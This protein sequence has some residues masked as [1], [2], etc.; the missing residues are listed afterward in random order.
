MK[1]FVKSF[2]GFQARGKNSLYLT[3]DN[4]VI[5]GGYVFVGKDILHN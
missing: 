3:N 1:S 4:T 5:F 2:A